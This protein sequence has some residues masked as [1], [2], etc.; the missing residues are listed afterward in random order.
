MRLPL[1][2]ATRADAPLA[3]APHPLRPREPEAIAVA[4][5]DASLVVYPFQTIFLYSER[6]LPVRIARSLAV[7]SEPGR[8]PMLPPGG[9][10]NVMDHI[11]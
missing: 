9:L 7:L 8:V 6:V 2:R 3:M 4:S 5:A 10:E 11:E 1:G